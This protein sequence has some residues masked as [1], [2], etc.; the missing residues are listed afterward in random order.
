MSGTV[1]GVR[2]TADRASDKTLACGE[3]KVLCGET[4]N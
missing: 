4:D 2:E 1:L 3:V